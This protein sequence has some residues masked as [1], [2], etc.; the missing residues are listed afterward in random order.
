MHAGV[1]VTWI[2]GNSA[3]VFLEGSGFLNSYLTSSLAQVPSS[4]SSALLYFIVQFCM[5]SLAFN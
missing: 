1:D 4:E 5:A 2:N 3:V